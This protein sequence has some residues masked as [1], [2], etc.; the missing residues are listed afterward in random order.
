[1]NAV[2]EEPWV[3]AL[4][5]TDLELKRS[6]LIGLYKDG[7]ISLGKAA[8]LLG[9]DRFEFMSLLKARGIHL[10]YGL[11][12]YAQDLQTIEWLEAR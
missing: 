7:H 5:L 9:I 11:E 12:D 10:N 3:E 6:L 8:E 4:H 2:L 1:M